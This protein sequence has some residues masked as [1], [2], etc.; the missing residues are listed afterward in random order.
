MQKIQKTIKCEILSFL[1]VSPEMDITAMLFS[2]VYS[3]QIFWLY[4]FK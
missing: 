1:L 3:I 4:K 2:S